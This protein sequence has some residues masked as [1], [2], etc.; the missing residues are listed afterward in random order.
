MIIAQEPRGILELAQ[1]KRYEAEPS[2][3]ETLIREAAE[4]YGRSQ[5]PCSDRHR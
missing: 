5:A 4:D 1:L 3:V 2:V